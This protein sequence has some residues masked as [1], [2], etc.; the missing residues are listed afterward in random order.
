MRTI[1]QNLRRIKHLTR[2]IT[3]NSERIRKWCSHFDNE[4][5]QYDTEKLIQSVNDMIVEKG[6]IRHELHRTNVEIK[7]LFQGKLMSV[8]ELII[9][10]SLTLP[11]KIATLKLLK[12]REKGYNQVDEKLKVVMNYD[13]NERDKKIDA[14][15]YTLEEAMD[16]LDNI[17]I[18]TEITL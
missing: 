16:V 10:V 2:K 4:E 18:T 15:E 1:Y 8:D 5:T 11:D 6:N 13:P 9:L 7:V 17:N 3:K 12:R 14:L